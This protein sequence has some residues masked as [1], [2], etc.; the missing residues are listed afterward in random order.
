MILIVIPVE[1]ILV[2]H[3]KRNGSEDY[4]KRVMEMGMDTLTGNFYTDVQFEL[5]FI[6]LTYNCLRTLLLLAML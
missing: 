4:S 5:K 2:Q 1:A 6:L 3:Q